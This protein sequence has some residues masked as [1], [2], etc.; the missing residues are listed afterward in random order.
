VI[1]GLAHDYF[2]YIVP[3][4]NYALNP[5]SPYLAEAEGDHYEETY[6]LG[7]DVE[8]QLVDP[9]LELVAWRP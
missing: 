1:F 6:S 4:Y 2:G 7:P 5:E 8:K 9:L 3:S